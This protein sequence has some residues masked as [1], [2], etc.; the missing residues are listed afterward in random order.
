MIPPRVLNRQSL[1]KRF[2]TLGPSAWKTFV[3]EVHDAHHPEEA[4]R[5]IFADCVIQPTEDRFLFTV[6][7]VDTEFTVDCLEER[8]WSFH[9]V[10][11]VSAARGLLKSAVSRRRDLDFVW[12]PSAHLSAIQL[13]ASPSWIK[14]DFRG[15]S[16][17]PDTAVQDLSV[18]VRGREA[19]PLLDLIA[20]NPD[21]PYAVSVSRLGVDLA[22]PEIGSVSEAVDRY[23]LFVAK[24]DSF[25]LHQ[26]VVSSVVANYRRLVEAAEA[27]AMSF[28]AIDDFEH[29]HED[30]GGGQYRGGPI[31][32]QFSRPLDDVDLFLDGLLSSREPFRLWGLAS[33]IGDNYS[34]IE[35]VDL[36]VG[37]RFRLEVSPEYLRIFLRDGGCG[38]T[39][40]RLVS[41]LQHH[42]DGGIGASDPAI[43]E[44]LVPMPAF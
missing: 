25:G 18:T 5:K 16:L 41:N 19:Q 39:V 33:D 42:V 44:H 32:L 24:G 1:E 31:E 28:T 15:R 20:S 6:K 40:A 27:L 29:R 13:G 21:F 26:S 23:A 17:L 36:H 35:A 37:Q 11:P 4:L 8:F 14:T 38:N 3:M 43:Q 10:S 9:S 34:E 2:L 30:L 7:A 12:L 22:D